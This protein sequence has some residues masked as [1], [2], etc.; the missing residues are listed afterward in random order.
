MV[1]RAAANSYQ[2]A[3]KNR[4]IRTH[5]TVNTQIITLGQVVKCIFS[6]GQRLLVE[7]VLLKSE[8]IIPKVIAEFKIKCFDIFVGLETTKKPTVK[9]DES[10]AV[11]DCSKVFFY[12]YL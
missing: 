9:S 11:T 12:Y 6:G 5:A 7:W 8:Q 3:A 4:S 10:T 2:L 1:Q